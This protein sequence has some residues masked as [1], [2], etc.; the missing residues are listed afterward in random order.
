VTS[1]SFKIGTFGQAAEQQAV[2]R[3]T[4]Q[5]DFRSV[6]CNMVLASNVKARIGEERR[7]LN[8]GQMARNSFPGDEITAR[9]SNG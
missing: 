3:V 8:A 7:Y 6:F 9:T 4:D 2:K 1:G 5:S